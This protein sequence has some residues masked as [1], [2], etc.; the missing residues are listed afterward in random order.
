MVAKISVKLCGKFPPADDA[1]GQLRRLGNVPQ[2]VAGHSLG[3]R[4]DDAY[5]QWKRQQ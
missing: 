2:L 3:V 4:P 1:V 5:K